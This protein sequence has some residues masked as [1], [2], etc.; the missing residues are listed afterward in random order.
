MS[1]SRLRP[2]ANFVYSVG[3]YPIPRITPISQRKVSRSIFCCETLRSIRTPHFLIFC[4]KIPGAASW[5]RRIGIGGDSYLFASFRSTVVYGTYYSYV[6][7]ICIGWE[8]RHQ[9]FLHRAVLHYLVNE[10]YG[11]NVSDCCRR[12][13]LRD[14][15]PY[16]RT[17]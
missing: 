4:L 12:F 14:L 5:S 3:T 7:Y 8:C 16:V 13:P 9:L 2:S 17:K 15:L 11:D 6:Q 10:Q 1:V